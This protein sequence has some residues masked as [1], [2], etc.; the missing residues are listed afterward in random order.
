MH[1]AL[2]SFW[3][4]SMLV[5]IPVGQVEEVLRRHQLTPVPLAPTA[6]GGVMN[7][8][9]QIVL[10]IDLRTLLRATG[11]PR[12]VNPMHVVVRSQDAIHSLLVDEIGEVVDVSGHPLSRVPERLDTDVREVTVGVYDLPGRLI[13]VLDVERLVD[14]ALLQRAA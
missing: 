2:L 7:L 11:R 3:V 5:G 9:G 14:P 6:V 12:A 13:L 1:D 8:R 4:G 10:A